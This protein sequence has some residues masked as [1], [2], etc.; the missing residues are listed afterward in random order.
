MEG[1]KGHQ[2]TRMKRARA[3]RIICGICTGLLA[4]YSA[5][6]QEVA[7]VGQP[8]PAA[9]EAQASAP[10]LSFKRS[11][12]FSSG[13]IRQIYAALDY[14]RAQQP[15]F[16]PQTQDISSS[17]RPVIPNGFAPSFFLRSIMY[18]GPDDW[19]IWLNDKKLRPGQ[20]LQN[21]YI[22]TV[23]ED[24]VVMAWHPPNLPSIAPKWKQTLQPGEKRREVIRLAAVKGGAAENIPAAE[25]EFVT[26]TWDYF[27]AAND[28]AVDSAKGAV[29]F[30]LSPHQ[31]FVT[32]TLSIQEGF[33]PHIQPMNQA[34]E[35][36]S[37]PNGTAATDTPTLPKN[38][39]VF[40]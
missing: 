8:V 12:M 9:T 13:E 34:A 19:V 29:R 1:V 3:I 14:S 18:Y 11:L 4:C 38:S 6:A 2:R 10:E 39:Q 37:S 28:V 22:V 25:P 20:G 17:S 21:F 7:E 31:S 27:D 36:S 40:Q 16:S 24:K 30:V 15:A 33:S 23:L 5:A 32:R 35:Q 26:F